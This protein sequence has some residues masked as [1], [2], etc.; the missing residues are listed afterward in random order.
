M[1]LSKNPFLIHTWFQKSDQNRIELVTRLVD[2]REVPDH[3]YGWLAVLSVCLCLFLGNT[4]WFSLTWAVVGEV[5]PG[6]A[7][8]THFLMI[9]VVACLNLGGCPPGDK[10]TTKTCF[11]LIVSRFFLL[12]QLSRCI[13]TDLVLSLVALWA[14]NKDW[15]YLMKRSPLNVDGLYIRGIHNVQEMWSV[16]KIG[17]WCYARLYIAAFFHIFLPE[18]FFINL[19]S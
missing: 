1:C 4:G 11:P 2:S 16:T 7:P 3:G 6:L 5:L 19:G 15:N 17:L 12:T 9:L 18:E 8:T 10:R 14:Y 13:P